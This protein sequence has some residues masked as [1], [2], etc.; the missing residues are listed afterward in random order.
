MKKLGNE[1]FVASAPPAVVA[2]EQTKKADAEARIAA[3]DERMAS[4]QS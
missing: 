1:R 2:A 3:L 4:M